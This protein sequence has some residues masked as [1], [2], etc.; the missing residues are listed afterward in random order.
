MKETQ[1]GRN[2][3]KKISGIITYHFL[4]W[5]DLR[6]CHKKRPTSAIYRGFTYMK[7]YVLNLFSMK[8][9]SPRIV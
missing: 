8:I 9:E 4:L 1:A 6:I 7:I 2:P 3:R 5:H